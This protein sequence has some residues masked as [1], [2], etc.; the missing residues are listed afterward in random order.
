MWPNLQFRL[1]LV[2]F[3]EHILNGKLHFLCSVYYQIRH[4]ITKCDSYFITKC[5]KSFLKDVTAFLLQNM[6]ALLKN[7]T[8]QL[9][10][11]T[12]TTKCVSTNFMWFQ[13]T[14][15]KLPWIEL[16]SFKKSRYKYNIS[17]TRSEIK[18]KPPHFLNIFQFVA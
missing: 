7:A 8:N 14:S 9:Q 17:K 15:C 5:K 4:I 18:V 3:T 16:M 10:I 2:T 13:C 11:E 6:T 12:V 1:D